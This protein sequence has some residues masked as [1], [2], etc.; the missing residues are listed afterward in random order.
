MSTASVFSRSTASRMSLPA[1]V[2]C[3]LMTSIPAFAQL[4][5]TYTIGGASPSYA[6][7]TAAVSALSA[8][9]SGPVTFNVRPGTYTG[10]I[11]IAAVPGASAAN[12]ITFQSES[13]VNTSVTLSAAGTTT[14]NYVVQLNGASWIRFRNMT[15]INT[16]TTSGTVIRFHTLT[17]S[18][19]NIVDGCV[20][21]GPV[22]TTTGEPL[23][24][25][26]GTTVNHA[27]NTFRN[28]RFVNGSRGLH[29]SGTG[30]LRH[31]NMLIENN[32]MTNQS[33]AAIW[34]NVVDNPTI[35]GNVMNMSTTAT[36]Q[37]YGIY[38]NT[39]YLGFL[40]E[41]NKINLLGTSGA[42]RG[43]Q[44]WNSSILP[45]GFIRNNF[46]TVH[47][48]ASTSYCF[49]V[50]TSGGKKIY[51]NTM[52]MIGTSASSRTVYLVLPRAEGL[53]FLNNIF[54]NTGPG[55]A[56]YTTQ[57]TARIFVND[58][59]VYFGQLFWDVAV[60]GLAGMRTAN[61][62]DQNSIER[63][64]TFASAPTGDLHLGGASQNDMLLTGTFIPTVPDDIDGDTRVVPYR[65]ADEACYLSPSWVDY[66]ITDIN[67]QPTTF[68][69]APGQVYV[70]FNVQQPI[71]DATVSATIN[72]YSVTTNQLAYTTT[73]SA[74]KLYGQPLSARELI[75]L[76]GTLPFGF[77][78]IEAVF[79][80]KNSCGFYLTFT[81]AKKFS[82]LLVAPGMEPCIVWPGDVNNDGIAN[83]GDRTALNKYIFDANL[84]PTWLTGPARFRADYATNPM[85]Y[86]TW[87]AQVS[88]PWQTPQGCFMDADGNGMVNNFDLLGVKANF[89]KYHGPITPK[90][91]ASVQPGTFDIGSNYPNPF[92]PS[93]TLQFSVPEKSTVSLV[94][95]DL[96]GRTVATLVAGDVEAGVHTAIFDASALE[97]GTYM[98]RYEA[99]GQ[100]SGLT[101]ARTIKMTLGK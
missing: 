57:T 26:W 9:V 7:F 87:E 84:R 43:I 90:T 35:R 66:N 28:N 74:D 100:T 86:L 79:T 29:F 6:T 34:L 18:T 58:Y 94:V 32:T 92:N 101:F 19:N 27:N 96:L 31:A 21:Q 50:S 22:V 2:C 95:T 97:S 82:M 51:S 3:F 70:D 45:M 63:A 41:K 64:V 53:E 40:I 61:G 33:E 56:F 54:I 39:L 12:T 75:N 80:S 68:V 17:A 36:V 89:L 13:G 46:I 78:R 72:F 38:L 37:Q 4:S 20:L 30:S 49:Y 10:A 59:N 24:L 93:T 52:A 65:G 99:T 69:S 71:D 11:I 73:I 55:H 77:Y 81:H 62:M 16:N 98:A 91:G 88:A 14:D 8:G 5:G 47:G 23:S 1:L 44:F 85:T 76:P 83:Y 42:K 67:G 48:G 15:L 60:T 25:V